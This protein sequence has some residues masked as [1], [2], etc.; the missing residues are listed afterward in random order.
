MLLLLLLL[1]LLLRL[2]CLLWLSLI[3]RKV[4]LSPGLRPCHW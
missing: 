3:R 1:L 2:L 4:L